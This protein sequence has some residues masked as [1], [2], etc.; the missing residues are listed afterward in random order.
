VEC[1][2]LLSKRKFASFDARARKTRFARRVPSAPAR[3]RGMTLS[4]AGC[5]GALMRLTHE[6]VSLFLANQ[7]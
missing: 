7:T 1:S 3:A 6:K 5:G 4:T 2:Q